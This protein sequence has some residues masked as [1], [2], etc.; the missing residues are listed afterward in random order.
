MKEGFSDVMM[1]A[2]LGMSLSEYL[3]WHCIHED[4]MMEEVFPYDNAVALRISCVLEVS[5]DIQRE[6]FGEK[7]IEIKSKLHDLISQGM[8]ITEPDPN[9]LIERVDLLLSSFEKDIDLAVARKYVVEYLKFCRNEN[10]EDLKLVRASLMD[11]I[12]MYKNWGEKTGDHNSILDIW[13]KIAGTAQEGSV[14]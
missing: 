9:M 12:N 4:G 3:L 10:C 6:N 14:S 7:K 11:F 8:F 2:T 5:F 1:I 13:L